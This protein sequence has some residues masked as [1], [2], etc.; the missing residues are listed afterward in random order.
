VECE[1]SAEEPITE[2]ASQAIISIAVFDMIISEFWTFGGLKVY[3][4][5]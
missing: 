4:I 2:N 5:Q 1:I 3:L